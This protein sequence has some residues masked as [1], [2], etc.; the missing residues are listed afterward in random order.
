MNRLPSIAEAAQRIRRG[1]TSPGE[2]VEFCLDRIRRLDG[3]LRAWVLVDEELARAAA[4]RC[5]QEL[6]AGNDRGPLHGIPLGIKDIVDV[7]GW[8]TAAGSP[9]LADH[10]PPRDAPLVRQLRDAGAILLGKTVTTQFACFDPPGTRNP[11]DVKRTPGGSS[12]GSAAATAVGMCCG[13]IGSQTGG[14]ITRPASYCGVAGCKPTRGLVSTDGLVPV[15]F[16]LDHPGPLARRVSDLAIMLAAIADPNSL[17]AQRPLPDYQCLLEAGHPPRLG[18]FREFFA[19]R[20]SQS[21][22]QV[23]AAALARLG[24]A[25]IEIAELPLPADF[26]LALVMHRR[27][28]AVEAA[29]AHSKLLPA[30]APEDYAPTVRK[31]LHEGHTTRAVDYAEALAYREQFAAAVE[32]ALARVDAVIVPATTTT[33]PDTSTTGD[34]AFN[35]PW[36]FAGVPTVSFPCGLAGDGLPVAVQLVGRSHSEATLLAAAQWCER[37]L[38]FDATSAL[39]LSFRA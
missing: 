19:Q 27:V 8:P 7:A 38:D 9:L 1:Q 5:E 23:F 25:G 24:S 39:P 16:H 29:Q 13:A 20:C 21:V 4:G 17:G 31:L 22:A 34:P 11:Y 12:S 6:A 28:M 37:R 35:A 3:D 15:S 14:S 30:A 10:V 36:S 2:L 26:D 33:A 18:L 32:A